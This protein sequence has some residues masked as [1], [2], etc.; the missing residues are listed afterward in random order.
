[1]TLFFAIG[2][3][4]GVAIGGAAY[5]SLESSRLLTNLQT[6]MCAIDR[7]VQA[8]TVRLG[9]QTG[10]ADRPAALPGCAP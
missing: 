3:I 10:D 6:D 7:D 9:G 8:N 5:W 4:L 2:I 1:M